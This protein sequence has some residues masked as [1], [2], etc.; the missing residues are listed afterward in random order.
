M[1]LICGF[2]FAYDKSRFSHDAAH[3]IVAL[4]VPSMQLLANIVS[5]SLCK[6]ATRFKVFIFAYRMFELHLIIGSTCACGGP[7]TCKDIIIFWLLKCGAMKCDTMRTKVL[8]CV[9][10]DKGSRLSTQWLST[11][12]RGFQPS[13]NGKDFYIACAWYEWQPNIVQVVTTV[14]CQCRQSTA[15]TKLPTQKS[16]MIQYSVI[17]LKFK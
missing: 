16:H 8:L 13:H 2:A 6:E 3:L 10:V 4:A 12:T 11:K 15:V 5:I 1:K 14:G 9:A 7:F 17:N